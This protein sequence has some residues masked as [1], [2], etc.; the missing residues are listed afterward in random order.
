MRLTPQE[1]KEIAGEEIT[2]AG[3][4]AGGLSGGRPQTVMGW[5]GLALLVSAPLPAQPVVERVVVGEGMVAALTAE[6]EIFLEA[7]PL[8]SEGLLAFSRRLTGSAE[9]APEIARLNGD[10]LELRVG[11]RYR[12]PYDR[13][14]P[15]LQ[16]QVMRSLFRDDQAGPDG[17]RHTVRGIGPLKRESLWHLARWFTGRGEHY[18][19]LRAA[20]QLEEEELA[21]GQVVTIPAELL[22]APFRAVPAG[23]P[24]PAAASPAST[25][26]E[27]RRDARGA[28][29]VY[30]LKPGEALYSSVVVR[31]TG[32]ILAVDVNALAQ[33]I[34]TFS[35][36]RDVTDIPVGYE[37]RVPL[38]LLLPEH[39]PPGDPRRRAYEESLQ[40][41]SAF[42]NEV[43]TRNLAGIT[44][45]LDAGHGGSDVGASMGGVWES[46][47]VYD[48][49]MR[50]KRLLETRSTAQ[51]FVT[52]RDGSEHR[53]PDRDVLPFS[54]GHAVLTDPPYP[55]ED[56]TVGVHLRWYLANSLFRRAITR[57]APEKVVFLSIHG[58][59][60]HPSLRGMMTYVPGAGLIGDGHGK[61][62]AAYAA[63][64][65]VR[66]SPRVSFSW[67]E[68][69][70]SEGLSRQLAQHLVEAFREAGMPIHP[71]KPVRE[72]IIRR[73]GEAWVPAVLRYNAVPA[74]VLVEIV[75]LANPDDRRL[76]Q[77]REHR[78]RLAGAIF[79]GLLRYYGEGEGAPATAVAAASR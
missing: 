70:R 75:N 77:T 37:I 3:G 28:Y 67:R 72:K 15:E 45:I 22:L 8:K 73:R 21:A 6:H 20:N 40:A 36:I 29:A 50:L 23:G 57:G 34:A 10:A 56:S 66:E 7:L 17:W 11:V 18:V 68:R 60:L 47:Y 5:V 12:V 9:T 58:D 49:T 55:I 69:V 35:G 62:G 2:A 24:A 61:S 14:L 52:T 59:S 16:G 1:Y 63:R 51:V 27:Y 48:V 30:R 43:R 44:V 13:L 39:L 71:F 4:P 41:S 26:L 46:L 33:E 79:D 42:S 64:R 54:R 78:E 31:F 25:E 38:E 74:K 76:L 65:E 32:R 53:I 19:A